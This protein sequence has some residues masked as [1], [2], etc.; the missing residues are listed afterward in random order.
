M[1]L[2]LMAEDSLGQDVL[3]RCWE[4]CSSLATDLGEPVL[5]AT[6]KEEVLPVSEF[7]FPPDLVG[8]GEIVRPGAVEHIGH[9]HSK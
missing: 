4:W 2:V 5:L 7:V 1:R 8:H 6:I 9:V 3:E